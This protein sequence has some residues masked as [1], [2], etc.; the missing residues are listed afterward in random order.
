MELIKHTTPKMI[1]SEE[2]KKIRDKNDVYMAEYYDDN[3]NLIPEHQ[4]YYTTVIFVPNDFTEDE[5]NNLYMEE[6]V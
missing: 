1:I 2:G 6:E 4:P 5:M 3:G